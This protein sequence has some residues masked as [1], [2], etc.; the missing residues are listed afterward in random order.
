MAG[1]SPAMTSRGHP[2]ILIGQY[3]PPFVRRVALALRLYGIGYEH[4]SWSTFG[5]GDKIAP[6][7]ASM[8]TRRRRPGRRNR[9]RCTP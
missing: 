8:L 3:D 6:F 1:S 2:V 9:S 7:H 4:R 5:D